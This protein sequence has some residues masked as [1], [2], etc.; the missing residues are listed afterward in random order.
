MLEKLMPNNLFK[1]CF[2]FFVCVFAYILSGVL[3]AEIK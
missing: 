1:C 3:S 2:K